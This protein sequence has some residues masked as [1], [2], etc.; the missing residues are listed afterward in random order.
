[1]RHERRNVEAR[2]L[3]FQPELHKAIRPKAAHG[4]PG[5]CIQEVRSQGPARAPETGHP[6][7]HAPHIERTDEQRKPVGRKR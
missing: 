3:C 7:D 6:A 1:M 5:G 4:K 2:H